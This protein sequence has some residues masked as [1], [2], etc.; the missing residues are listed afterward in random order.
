MSGFDLLFGNENLKNFI[1]RPG[2]SPHAILIEGKEG[3]GKSLAALLSACALSCEAPD[4]PC[5]DCESCRKILSGGTPDVQTVTT[6]TGKKFISVDAIRRVRTDAYNSPVELPVRVYII[7]RADRMNTPA[8]NAFL[9]VLEEPPAH[10]RF[11]LTAD[12]S[13]PL[14]PTVISR[15]TL[16]RAENV[17]AS[18]FDELCEWFGEVY[19]RYPASLL[20]SL[21]S[22]SAPK[23]KTLSVSLAK[24]D[25]RSGSVSEIFDFAL[26]SGVKK[27]EL[28]SGF[29]DAFSKNGYTV[30]LSLKKSM[31][32][33]REDYAEFVKNS[34]YAVRDLM[35]V[36]K[37]DGSEL[38]YYR[39]K[40]ECAEIS[41]SV[42][43]GNLLRLEKALLEAE[44]EIS[45]N[46]NVSLS[47][48]KLLINAYRAKNP[49][50]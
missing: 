5:L 34:V 33:K 47:Q 50:A 16:F 41:K 12:S 20:S 29:I 46:C 43:F 32:K 7:D 31:P 17:T 15:C 9:K 49:G 6:E 40:A 42:S 48:A 10:A 30:L 21:Y 27:D 3:S 1:T 14:L 26:S 23:L 2:A 11:I 38:L 37:T 4:R 44:S 45:A 35:A 22:L 28:T 8:Q 25:K 36:K 13:A 39:D 19:S 18:R 24:S